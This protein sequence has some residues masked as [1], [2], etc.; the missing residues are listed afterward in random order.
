VNPWIQTASGQAYDLLAPDPS[1]IV[2]GDVATALSNLIRFT[3]H[4]GPYTVAQ[5]SVVGARVLRHE[6]HADGV[7]RAFLLHD[8]HEAVTGDV[9]SPVKRALRS[10]FRATLSEESDGFYTCEEDRENTYP[11]DPWTRFEEFHRLAFARR[12][13]TP[14]E[15]PKAVLEMD[16][17][18]L[19]TEAR[20]L[21]L[22]PPK[23]WGIPAE[24]IEGLRIARCWSPREARAEFLDECVRLGVV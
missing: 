24:P 21:L 9:A 6:G 13:G 12:F 16:L 5:H 23:P 19:V 1:T 14:R 10:L 15:L 22:P 3:G 17:R 18:M 4:A 7:Q 11:Q 20:D 8:A 2:L